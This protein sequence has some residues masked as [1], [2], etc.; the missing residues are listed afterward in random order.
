MFQYDRTQPKEQSEPEGH[1]PSAAINE[2]NNELRSMASRPKSPHYVGQA[3]Y[4]IDSGVLDLN[5]GEI[6]AGEKEINKSLNDLSNE[7]QLMSGAQQW[8]E[9]AASCVVSGD[10]SDAKDYL[11]AAIN[12]LHHNGYNLKDRQLFEGALTDLKNGNTSGAISDITKGGNILDDKINS[13]TNDWNDLLK[14]SYDV[15]QGNILPA[16]R[17]MLSVQENLSPGQSLMKQENSLPAAETPATA[18]SAPPITVQTTP[19]LDSSRNSMAY[20]AKLGHV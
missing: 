8:G 2:V 15:S 18:R 12:D 20:L 1:L 16:E 13:V 10:K 11:K 5:T 3:R 4:D 14:D 9:L 6:K 19:D 17:N 7:C